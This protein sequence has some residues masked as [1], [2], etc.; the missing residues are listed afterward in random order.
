MVRITTKKFYKIG[1]SMLSE[2]SVIPKEQTLSI[3]CT[4]A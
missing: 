2:F 3:L 4:V 1:L